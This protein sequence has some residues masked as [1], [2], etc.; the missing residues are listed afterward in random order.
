[1]APAARRVCLPDPPAAGLLSRR[2]AG[3]VPAPPGIFLFGHLHMP[4]RKV[5]SS[6]LW[7][8][9]AL[10]GENRRKRQPGR[11]DRAGACRQAACLR[12]SR[13]SA[14]WCERFA[15]FGGFP[16]MLVDKRAGT[17]HCAL[18]KIMIRELDRCWRS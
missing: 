3:F 10:W 5:T 18:R 2:F 7:S 16:G 17:G 12:S 11:A 15:P 6:A 8:S 13:S 14:L 9:P 4:S 1:M